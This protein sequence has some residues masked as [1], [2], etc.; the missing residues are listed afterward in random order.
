MVTD[1][2]GVGFELEH[3]AFGLQVQRSNRS[4]TLPRPYILHISHDKC[5]TKWP[6]WYF[7][8]SYRYVILIYSQIYSIL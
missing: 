3:G 5:L 7:L 6:A 2:R 4:A 8:K 1:K